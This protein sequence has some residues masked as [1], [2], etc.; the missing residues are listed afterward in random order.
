MSCNEK[1]HIQAQTSDGRAMFYLNGWLALAVL[2][3]IG[4]LLLPLLL[5]SQ[6]W[7]LLVPAA[8][9]YVVLLSG[10][11]TVQPNTA[12]VSTCFGRYS[13]VLAEAGFFWIVPRVYQTQRVSLRTSNYTTPT[14]KVND[15][16]GTPIEVAAAIVYRI[17]NP[18]AAVL[19]VENVH[20]FIQVQSES[21]LRTLATCHPYAAGDGRESLS[22]HSEDIMH[23]FRE[24]VQERVER[25]G[26]HVDEA[27]F[28]HLA[29]APEIA[30]AMLRKQQAEAVIAAR[31]T[32]VRGAIS[33]VGGTVRE[34]ENR[35][36]VNMS[37]AEK[38][39]LVTNMMTVLLSEENAAPVLNV[40][41]D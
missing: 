20:T 18:A 2:A 29:Y 40:S 6:L 15:A 12:L 22:R 11:R 10:F 16:S 24:M 8:M 37:D 14:L 33:M 28:T 19:D 21:A 25:A 5:L 36:I 13:G 4:L 35:Q 31:H 7:F 39:R 26:I 41:G 17:S 3:G 32:L 23:Q 34:L 27:R 1:S 38:A 30:Q 9:V